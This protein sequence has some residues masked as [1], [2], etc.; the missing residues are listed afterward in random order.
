MI[1][2]QEILP[3]YSTSWGYPNTKTRLKKTQ[4]N[5]VAIPHKY[6]HKNFSK[7]LANWFIYHDQIR[8][9]P[10]CNIYLASQK[11]MNCNTCH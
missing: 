5:Y 2:T 3:A 8:L 9:I 7:I 4:E 10:E 6:N 11:W 1:G